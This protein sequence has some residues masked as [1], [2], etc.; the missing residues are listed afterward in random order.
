MYFCYQLWIIF[1]IQVRKH[2]TAG[3]KNAPLKNLQDKQDNRGNTSSN[4]L[5][6]IL[7]KLHDKEI[8]D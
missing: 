3:M 8:P 1:H 7:L 4:L 2:N 6:G 5:Q